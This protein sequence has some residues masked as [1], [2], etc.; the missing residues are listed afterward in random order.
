MTRR[1][2]RVCVVD[3]SATVP[4]FPRLDECGIEVI[5]ALP[6]MIHALRT[7]SLEHDAV[8]VGA[9]PAQLRDRR[10]QSRLARLARRLPTVLVV[11]RVTRHAALVAANARVAAL[12]VRDAPP[13]VF[14]H[15]LRGACRGEVVY[16]NEAVASLLR[17][18]PPPAHA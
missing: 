2:L 11:P 7:P 18:V 13:A 3:P 8:V 9:Q 5:G 6:G 16:P 17:L 4:A 10:F 14:M 1:P 12:V 15:A